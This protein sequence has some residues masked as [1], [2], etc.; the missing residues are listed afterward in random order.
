[1][2]GATEGNSRAGLMCFSRDLAA[3]PLR[4]QI[5]A[6]CRRWV[7]ERF[8]GCTAELYT[9]VGEQEDGRQ[10]KEACTVGKASTYAVPPVG[11]A[12]WPGTTPRLTSN[13]R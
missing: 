11:S 8:P 7:E 10:E 2:A 6:V 3:A 12:S 1:M 5:A 13:C 4:E 9:V